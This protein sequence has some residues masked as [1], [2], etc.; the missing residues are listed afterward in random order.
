VLIPASLPSPDMPRP[1]Q[2]DTDTFHPRDDPPGDRAQVAQPSQV[3]PL[4]A[5]EEASLGGVPQLG[6]GERVQMDH[7]G[8]MVIG[9]DGRVSRIANWDK[10]TD[11]ER[12]VGG[13]MGGCVGGLWASW[14]PAIACGSRAVNVLLQPAA[15]SVLLCASPCT[16]RGSDLPELHCYCAVCGYPS[17]RLAAK[18]C[19]ALKCSLLTLLHPAVF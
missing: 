13:W 4:P 16:T 2:V 3:L 15:C 8:P 1:A 11:R 17:I 18:P 9:E 19:L 10:L 7:L 5:P 6:L 14:V 12:E